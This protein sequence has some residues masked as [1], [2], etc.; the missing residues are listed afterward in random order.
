MGCPEP[1]LLWAEQSQLS[2]PLPIALQFPDHLGSTLLDK[3]SLIYRNGN[4]MQIESG[5]V[6]AMGYVAL[7][8]KASPP[9]KR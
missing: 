5:E 1:P 2:Q 7:I 6:L 3:L 8:F 4:A 9:L